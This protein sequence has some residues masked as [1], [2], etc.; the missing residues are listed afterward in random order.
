MWSCTVKHKDH[1]LFV[2]VKLDEKTLQKQLDLDQSH[3]FQRL[4]EL[5]L[6]LL[7]VQTCSQELHESLQV[8]QYTFD[9]DRLSNKH[10]Y[11][12]S[13]RYDE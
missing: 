8:S 11:Q 13:Q 2:Y 5:S 7:Q 4:H 1:I 3:T 12:K 6:I 9:D 10:Y